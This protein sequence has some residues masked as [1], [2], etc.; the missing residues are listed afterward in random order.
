MFEKIPEN[1][2]DL[3]QVLHGCALHSSEFR[4]LRVKNPNVQE[5]KNN[6]RYSNNVLDSVFFVS[7]NI[8]EKIPENKV[9]QPRL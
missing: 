2:S 6:F 1:M 3:S 7:G 8:V 4:H 9:N 5:N